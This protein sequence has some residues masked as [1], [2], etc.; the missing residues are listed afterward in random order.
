[1]VIKYR[2]VR[3]EVIVLF[4]LGSFFI[5]GISDVRTSVFILWLFL[6]GIIFNKLFFFC[7]CRDGIF[8]NDF[9]VLDFKFLFFL[10]FLLFIGFVFLV[11]FFFLIF[12]RFWNFV[13]LNVFLII[14][15]F[16]F[17]LDWFFLE[18]NWVIYI[19]NKIEYMLKII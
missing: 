5:R 9:L 12:F 15:V 14:N 17:F 6:M 18:L 1:M 2:W 13:L 3:L 10:N 8:L 16:S 19:R 4:L 11:W 7:N